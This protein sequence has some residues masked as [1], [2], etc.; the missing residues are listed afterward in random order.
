[1]D[2]NN[3]S[4]HVSLPKPVTDTNSA[5][6]QPVAGQ[7]PLV[8]SAVPQQPVSAAPA[9]AEPLPVAGQ[10]ADTDLIEQAWIQ[11]TEALMR[12]YVND[13]HELA[14]QFEALKAEYVAQRF[15]KELKRQTDGQAK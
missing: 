13:P 5:V 7:S 9:Q 6:Q 1:M 11:R 4:S 15:G 3:S 14:R 2:T 10:A 8:P 12:Q